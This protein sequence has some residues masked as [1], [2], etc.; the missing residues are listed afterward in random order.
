[1]CR[2]EA[3]KNLYRHYWEVVNVWSSVNV[4]DLHC[5]HPFLFPY[6]TELQ[7]NRPQNGAEAPPGQ[8]RR[9]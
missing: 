9:S 3:G 7:S 2:D 6:H 5:Q 8:E 1:M 4:S